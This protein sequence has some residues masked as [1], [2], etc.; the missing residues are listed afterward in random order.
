MWSLVW[1]GLS[2]L[3][4][5]LSAKLGEQFEVQWVALRSG[6]KEI[7]SSTIDD[8]CD[9][10]VESVREDNLWRCWS[11]DRILAVSGGDQSELME[12]KSFP[13]DKLAQVPGLVQRLEDRLKKNVNLDAARNRLSIS[14]AGWDEIV[15]DYAR[16]IVVHG[17]SYALERMRKQ[18][19][20]IFAHDIILVI[21]KSEAYRVN[22]RSAHFDMVKIYDPPQYNFEDQPSIRKA[23]RIW[24]R[25][26]DGGYRYEKGEYRDEAYKAVAGGTGG[27]PTN[28]G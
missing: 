22:G 15:S 3:W 12:V 14:D 28:A 21:V 27:L 7:L 18:R 24:S 20:P 9:V 11:N 10:I 1:W 2:P 6:F 19:T 8:L 4:K 17:S 26:L 25:R 23:N 16:A 13:Q 5:V